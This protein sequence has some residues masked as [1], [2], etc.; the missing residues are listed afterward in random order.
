MIS[1]LFLTNPYS[2]LPGSF[3]STLTFRQKAP[4]YAPIPSNS[5]MS[6][7]TTNA[8]WLPLRNVPNNPPG[9]R[10]RPSARPSGCTSVHSLTSTSCRVWVTPPQTCIGLSTFR[11]NTI[12]IV[13]PAA[14]VFNTVSRQKTTRK[15]LIFT[16]RIGHGVFLL[17]SHPFSCSLPLLCTECV[18]D[19]NSSNGR[20]CD[21]MC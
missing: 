3:R 13:Q 15:I 5:R 20:Q 1:K 19:K 4:Y 8:G 11:R 6:Y 12:S 9:K 16:C 7:Y 14:P 21:L 2:A 10:Y 18:Y 17:S